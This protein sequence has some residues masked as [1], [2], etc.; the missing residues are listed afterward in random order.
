MIWYN[1]F[2]LNGTVIHMSINNFRPSRTAGYKSANIKKNSY[3]MKKVLRAYSIFFMDIYFIALARVW[4]STLD[5]EAQSLVSR[6]IWAFITNQH[7]FGYQSRGVIS[8]FFLFF[9]ATVLLKN[10]KKQHFICSNLTLFIVPFFLVSLFSLFFLFFLFFFHFF[11]FL[12]GDG[13]PAP[14]PPPEWRL[15]TGAA[16]LCARA[17]FS[18]I[19]AGSLSV[20]IY[21]DRAGYYTAGPGTDIMHNLKTK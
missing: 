13:S 3:N 15:C 6:L 14:P 2:N 19:K 18:D 11:I 20:R 5:H 9:N 16:R 1:T 21:P 4:G 10:W 12:G 8:T 7:K 17:G